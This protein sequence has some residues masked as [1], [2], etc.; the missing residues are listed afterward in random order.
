MAFVVKIPNRNGD[1][2]GRSR[3]LLK[4]HKKVLAVSTNIP[5]PALILGN[6]KALAD[7]FNRTLLVRQGDYRTDHF[8]VSFQHRF[9]QDEI[10]EIIGIIE[11]EFQEAFGEDRPYLIVVHA[12]EFKNKT[13]EEILEERIGGA[14]VSS[15][16]PI[17]GT[18]FHVVMG[19]NTEGKGI[20]LKKR[21]Y[22]YFKCRVAEK[23]QKFANER[24]REVFQHFL[25]GKRERDYYKKGELYAPEKNEK[26]WAKKILK[27]I[28]NALEE[29]EIEKAIQILNRHNANIEVFF[30]SPYN[31]KKLKEPTPYIILPRIGKDGMFAMRLRKAERVLYERYKE[32]FESAE[33][34]Y[35]FVISYWEAESGD[36]GN[37]EGMERI[38]EEFRK[39]ER[40]IR[41]RIREIEAEMGKYQ[42]NAEK[43][44]RESRNVREIDRGR[45]TT[46]EEDRGIKGR[47]EGTACVSFVA[48]RNQGTHDKARGRIREVK[49]EL[50]KLERG[51]G[52]FER[53]MRKYG[54][55][56]ND[57]LSAYRNSILSRSCKDF[58]T[59]VS[60]D[61][62][63]LVREEVDLIFKELERL[64]M[65]AVDGYEES[66]ME[67]FKLSLS[68]SDKPEKSPIAL[69]DLIERQTG[70][71]GKYLEKFTS[72]IVS[73]Y[74]EIVEK[75]PSSVSAL[76][77]FLKE[78]EKEMKEVFPFQVGYLKGIVAVYRG[79]FSGE[80][81]EKVLSYLENW[82][83]NQEETRGFLSYLVGKYV[84]DKPE[85]VEKML[86]IASQGNEE[87]KF[88]ALQ[89]IK[90]YFKNQNRRSWGPR[91]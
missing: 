15:K 17:A 58:E 28:T 18:S 69:L 59:F 87:L 65:M 4:D 37:S 25:K 3:Y 50:Q 23:L 20:R 22:M 12:E 44:R 90:P 52:E 34:R 31:D 88:L 62:K 7:D 36:F 16:S 45:G 86:E 21:D 5:S 79:L 29:D 48:E 77:N 38:C 1:G 75:R 63:S 30:F 13:P 40:E 76:E 89:I 46:E 47:R 83:L 78:K 81:H 64:E 33:K 54:H 60:K 14:G 51:I 9:S 32:V 24:E 49:E 80:T 71:K 39:A 43:Y 84:T 6:Y 56:F 73:A 66:I 19:R 42:R 41:E 68:W 85:V 57:W 55:E 2:A 8:V 91:R 27:D 11:S 72:K 26:V 61:F 67:F 53:L 70:G 82:H 74:R 35:R 10:E